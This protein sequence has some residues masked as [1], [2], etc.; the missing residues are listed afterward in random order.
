MKPE[1]SY[2]LSGSFASAA[3]KTGNKNQN[4]EYGKSINAF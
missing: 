1:R 2:D 3:K 4:A